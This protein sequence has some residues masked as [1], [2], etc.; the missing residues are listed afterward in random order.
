[1]RMK[2]ET[3]KP[4]SKGRCV[5]QTLPPS[6]PLAVSFG[7]HAACVPKAAVI[8]AGQRADDEYTGRGPGRDAS[9]PGGA[10]G[11]AP[12]HALLKGTCHE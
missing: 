2:T 10:R 6:L 8:G 7:T 3:G 5:S 4:P 11:S 1:M 12:L 9:L